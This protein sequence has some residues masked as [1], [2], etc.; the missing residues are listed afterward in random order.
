MPVV[1]PETFESA[2]ADLSTDDRIELLSAIWSERGK[3]VTRDGTRLV[4][5]DGTRTRT[6]SFEP[7]DR[8]IDEG[9]GEEVDVL[10]T[11]DPSGRL[12]ERAAALDVELFD[13]SDVRS[14]LLYG[15]DRHVAKALYRDQ[16]GR[17]IYYSVAEIEPDPS[18]RERLPFARIAI[19]FVA[20]TLVFLLLFGVPID[21]GGEDATTFE[22]PDEAPEPQFGDEVADDT[23]GVVIE[24]PPHPAIGPG[25]TF[26]LE[27]V[28]SAHTGTLENASF[29]MESRYDGPDGGSSYEPAS[30]FERTVVVENGT[31]YRTE[32]WLFTPERIGPNETMTEYYADGDREYRRIHDGQRAGYDSVSID[33]AGAGQFVRFSNRTV[34]RF[35]R[36]DSVSI[37]QQTD[38]PSV[39]SVNVT[40][41][42]TPEALTENVSNYSATAEITDEGLVVSLDVQYYD[43]DANTTVT[44]SHTIVDVGNTTVLTPEWFDD[45]PD[46][47]RGS[48][49]VKSHGEL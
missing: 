24:N 38:G 25:G 44:M 21:Y 1:P 35:L 45:H 4:V 10:V 32:E 33:R 27:A 47:E 31:V 16:F 11:P 15:I 37:E 14:L 20:V 39:G 29:V 23:A 8:S 41:E 28:L 49:V 13:A 17:S 22:S 19:G 6:V 9:I 43:E 48:I 3:E 36:T 26:D 34:D 30:A 46:R 5:T 18:L 2:F 7:T 12:A 40:A 42:G